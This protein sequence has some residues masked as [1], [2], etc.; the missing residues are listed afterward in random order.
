MGLVTVKIPV[1]VKVGGR[2]QE[3][4]SRVMGENAN[5]FSK[6]AV[7]KGRKGKTF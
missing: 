2:S 4:R 6:V 3:L 7:G 5:Y 1:S